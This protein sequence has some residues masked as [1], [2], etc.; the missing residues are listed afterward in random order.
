MYNAINNSDKQKSIGG[1]VLYPGESRPISKD[2]I[3]EALGKGL[4]V[5]GYEAKP[6][7]APEAPAGP[8]TIEEVLKHSVKELTAALPEMS[9]EQLLALE[10]AEQKTETPRE[11]LLKAIEKEIARPGREPK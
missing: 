1:R 5:P 9:D 11:T 8:P 3:A 2:E 10:E 4:T 6:K 7:A